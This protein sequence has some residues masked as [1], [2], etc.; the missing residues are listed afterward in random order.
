[1]SIKLILLIT[2][3]SAYGLGVTITFIVYL[4]KYNH[5]NSKYHNLLDQFANTMNEDN[6]N[7]KSLV[8][9]QSPVN[10]ININD[11]R[12]DDNY[13]KLDNN[14]STLIQSYDIY[15]ES[16]FNNIFELTDEF[17]DRVILY[18]KD[19]N[20]CYL[21]CEILNDCYAFTRYHNYCYLKN[22]YDLTK[23]SDM[24]NALLIVKKNKT[25]TD[26]NKLDLIYNPTLYNLTNNSSENNNSNN[27]IKNLRSNN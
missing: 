23:K 27:N 11:N 6:I 8:K 1:M 12:N 19:I 4:I 10:Q 5:V 3:L 25:Y 17:N 18:S 9:D 14:Y 2:L 20:N 22:N 21:S 13:T 15:P 7:C 24:S 26:I 16:D